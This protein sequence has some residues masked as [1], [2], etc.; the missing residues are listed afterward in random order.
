MSVSKA[1]RRRVYQLYGRRCAR[2]GSR[3]H[4]TLDHKVPKA[5]GGHNG[6]DNL[7]V[8]CR[9]CNQKKGAQEIHYPTAQG[10]ISL[11]RLE[12]LLAEARRQGPQ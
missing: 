3:Q 1:K 7:Q 10:H 9:S 2:C 5:K 8:L 4:L 6:W 12:H 11:S